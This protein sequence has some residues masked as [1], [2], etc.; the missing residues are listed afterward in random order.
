MQ[1]GEFLVIVACIYKL[2][3]VLC[4][5]SDCMSLVCRKKSDY[6]CTVYVGES[7]GE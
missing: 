5:D 4:F 1:D 2:C 6:I 3:S 7:E